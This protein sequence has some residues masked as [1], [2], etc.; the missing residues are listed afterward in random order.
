MYFTFVSVL[1]LSMYY[2]NWKTPNLKAFLIATIYSIIMEIV[3]GTI[4]IR[5]SF[6]M[7]DI[8]AN[9]IGALMATLLIKYYLKS[10][11]PFT[12]K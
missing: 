5:R 11:F 6:D 8:I 3:Q 2:N 9:T 7:Y 1:L 4:C 12:L 10:F